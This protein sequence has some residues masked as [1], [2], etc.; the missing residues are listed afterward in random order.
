MEGE[1]EAFFSL[2]DRLLIKFPD[3]KAGLVVLTL[4]VSA[5]VIVKN[6]YQI[7]P[8]SEKTPEFSEPAIP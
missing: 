5:K 8:K 7:K 2:D 3:T 1:W 6:D 4:F